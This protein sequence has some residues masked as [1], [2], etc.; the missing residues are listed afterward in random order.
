[1]VVHELA[2]GRR[3]VLVNGGTDAR[4]LPTGHLA[5]YRE[6]TLFAMPFD[7]ERLMVTGGPV[8][9]QQGIQQALANLSGAAQAAWSDAGAMAFVPGGAT[10]FDRELVWLNRE[11]R[12]EPTT[13]PQ[14][15]FMTGGF[16]LALSPDGTLAA[17]SVNNTT[18]GSD[19]WVWTI[20]RGALTRL[21][22]TAA[23]ASP[24]WTPDGRRICYTQTD[25]VF[26][27]AA[28]GS[29]NPLSLFKFPG[30][31]SL[32]SISPNGTRLVFTAAPQPDQA[33]DIMIATLSP[34]T[35]IRPLI[36][37]RFGEGNPRI[38]PDGRWIAYTSIESGRIEVYVRPFPEVD[39]G[40]WQVSTDGGFDPRWA[41]NGRE[42]FF[43]SGGGPGPRLF[44]SSA[45]QPGVTFVAGKPTQIATS[46]SGAAASFA[47]DVAS[48]GRLLVHLPVTSGTAA[49][50]SRPHVVV[51]QHW[52]DELKARVPIPR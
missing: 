43:S 49:E 28:D 47:Y 11:G 15:G 17:V 1:M 22:F 31:N 38:S 32:G 29:G 8:P 48:D 52:F 37:T 20:A 26:C 41:K 33:A 51:V 10:A 23:T 7:E 18:T 4:V 2:T 3:T 44:W 46:P 6:A 21:T 40:R 30:L 35:E 24:V 39:Q 27:Q 50:V 14:R 5:Y 13:A 42:L 19:I 12:Q 16:G 25:E 45:I 36:K 34:P 9:V